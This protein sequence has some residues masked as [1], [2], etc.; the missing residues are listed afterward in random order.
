MVVA[1]FQQ[2]LF[3]LWCSHAGNAEAAAPWLVS[4]LPLASIVPENRLKCN[5]FL[6]RIAILSLARP[7]RLC[8]QLPT[9]RVG[10]ERDRV[11]A[12]RLAETCRVLGIG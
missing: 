2:R 12:V 6:V 4:W 8:P 1:S 11:A 3:W 7:D 10:K 5:S 9:D